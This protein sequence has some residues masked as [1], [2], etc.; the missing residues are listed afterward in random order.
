MPD[1]E[2]PDQKKQEEPKTQTETAGVPPLPPRKTALGYS[3]GGGKRRR[4]PMPGTRESC[5]EIAVDQRS[6]G[7]PWREIDTDRMLRHQITREEVDAEVRRR[8][9]KDNVAL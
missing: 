3:A 7:I 1:N 5:F 9:D 8:R 6:A 4:F 2:N